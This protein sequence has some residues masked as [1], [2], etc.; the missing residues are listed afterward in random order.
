MTTRFRNPTRVHVSFHDA[1]LFQFT[2]PLGFLVAVVYPLVIHGPAGDDPVP[3]PAQPSLRP[4]GRVRGPLQRRPTP[5]NWKFTH[6]DLLNLLRRIK[7]HQN[8]AEEHQLAA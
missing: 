2:Q 8:R 6:R 3:M 7:V 5:F 1:F 4:T